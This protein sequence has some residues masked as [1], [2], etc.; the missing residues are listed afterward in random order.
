MPEYP[1][2][3]DGSPDKPNK[4]GLAI[5]TYVQWLGSWQESYP[6][7]EEYEKTYSQPE[8]ETD[9]QDVGTE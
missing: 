8:T 1:W 9:E 5:L 6:Y 2:F 3:F 4:K 7:Y